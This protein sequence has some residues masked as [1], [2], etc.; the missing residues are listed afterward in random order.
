MSRDICIPISTAQAI[1]ET[2]DLHQV[3]IVAWDGEKTHVV[4]YG[5]NAADSANAA[6]GGNRIKKALGW[7]ESLN[8]ESPKV[9]ALQ[10]RIAEL[11]A[12]VGSGGL[13]EA[14]LP[15]ALFELQD[16]TSARRAPAPQVTPTVHVIEGTEH[17]RG[18]G[19]RPDGYVAFTTKEAAEAFIVDYDAKH[20]T[21]KHAPDEYTVYS[22]I[23]LKECSIGFY[24]AVAGRK[25]KHFDRFSELLE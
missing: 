18:W 9:I 15:Q 2:L 10:A 19:C 5:G 13:P 17:E 1:A 24:K 21:A 14:K 11:E 3:I 25:A 22:Y 12:Q 6:A 8:T 23:G 4:T 20:N 7:P 16:P